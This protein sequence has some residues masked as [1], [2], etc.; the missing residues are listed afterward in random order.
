MSSRLVP[1]WVVAPLARKK[2]REAAINHCL[3][4][5]KSYKAKIEG[6]NTLIH[7]FET[8]IKFLNAEI[9]VEEQK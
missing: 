4:S 8:R 1:S 6:S 9:E 2:D 3:V 7:H 5:I